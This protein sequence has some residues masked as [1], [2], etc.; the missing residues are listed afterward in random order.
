[1]PPR[2]LSPHLS[3]YKFKYTLTTSI[4]NRLTGIALSLGLVLLVY[5]LSAVAAGA[6]AQARAQRLLS[7]PPL[8]LIYLGLIFALC[9]HLCA[10]IRHLIWDTGRALERAQ[11]QRSAWLLTV[12]SIVLTLVVIYCVWGAGA[13]TP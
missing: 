5:W 9:Y 4:L 2:P 1:M 10:G 13:R 7:V 6:A 3:V 12:S 11:S 8:R